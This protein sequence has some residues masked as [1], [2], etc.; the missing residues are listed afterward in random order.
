MRIWKKDHP[1]CPSCYTNRKGRT[2]RKGHWGY[3]KPQPTR[4]LQPWEEA[5]MK[6]PTPAANGQA[7]SLDDGSLFNGLPDLKEFLTDPEWDDGKPRR[8]GTITFFCQDGRWKLSLN[9]RELER[10]SVV[11]GT[12]PEGCVQEANEGL[13]AG[14]LDW[15]ESTGPARRRR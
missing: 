2:N 8:L 5:D 14:D 9:D 1:F 3:A 12:T 13:R 4:R 10:F 7:G 11:T 6:R 15:R